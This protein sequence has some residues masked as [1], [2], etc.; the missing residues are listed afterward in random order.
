MISLVTL[1]TLVTLVVSGVAVLVALTAQKA[2]DGLTRGSGTLVMVT[3]I[4]TGVAVLVT[5][6]TVGPRIAVSRTGVL[7]SPLAEP[8]LLITLPVPRISI[9][10]VTV[11]AFVSGFTLV[12]DARIVAIR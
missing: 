12:A 5:Q 1:V 8:L 3:L 4:A 2:A 10:A 6:V 9:V 7:I 11:I